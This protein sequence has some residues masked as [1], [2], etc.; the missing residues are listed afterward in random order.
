MEIPLRT[1]FVLVSL[2]LFFD[3]SAQSIKESVIIKDHLI[4]VSIWKQEDGLPSWLILDMIKD[5]RGGLWIGTTEG[6]H[7][8][9]GQRFQKYLSTFSGVDA[10]YVF[11]AEDKN[12]NIWACQ[13]TDEHSLSFTILNPHTKDTVSFES[14]T[15]VS[16]P[17]IVDAQHLFR[18]PAGIYIFSPQGVWRYDEKLEKV[19]DYVATRGEKYFP[20][21]SGTFWKVNFADTSV[22]LL[23]SNG[24]EQAQFEKTGKLQLKEFWIDED[25]QLW[26]TRSDVDTLVQFTPMG[27]RIYPPD[28]LQM[29]HWG[30][31]RNLYFTNASILGKGYAIT[32]Q[33]YAELTPRYNKYS[34]L[35]NGNTIIPHLS[36]W[37]S[38]RYQINL[39]LQ[40]HY[41]LGP[42]GVVWLS[43]VGGIIRLKFSPLL[44][45]RQLHKPGNT[46]SIRQI[47][48]AG[49]GRMAVCSYQGLF[50]LDK[51]YALKPTAIPVSPVPKSVYAT[52]QSMWVGTIDKRVY[53]YF[54]KQNTYRALNNLDTAIML[55][56]NGFFRLPD[57][58]LVLGSGNGLWQIDSLQGT[59]SRVALPDTAVYFAHQ[60]QGQYW[61]GTQYVMYHWNSKTLHAFQ[62]PH[63]KGNTPLKT[64]HLAEGAEGQFWIA[65]D[66]GLLQW[67]PGSTSY[68]LYTHQE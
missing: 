43:G 51:D 21:P 61:L 63:Q 58:G 17:T 44:F 59:F 68:Q 4:E 12:R 49:P 7:R 22:R 65:T 30:N 34:V 20:G 48:R 56:A 16:Q 36:E 23:D 67:V 35:H 33:S 41:T 25:L 6:V 45:K 18:T 26:L 10:P 64:F 9:D 29:N 50:L 32:G 66:Q 60:A 5:H 3:V 8:F 39:N 24:Q 53:Q 11:L 13:R 40:Q 1:L 46:A 28:Q 15:G 38:D 57:K 55:E 27:K 47:I 14:Y 37:L 62:N 2:V 54:P 31:Q 42:P 19:A 52:G